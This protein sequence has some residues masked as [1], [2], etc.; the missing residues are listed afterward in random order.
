MYKKSRKNIE[1][2]FKK[3]ALDS[4]DIKNAKSKS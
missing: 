2:L 3:N 1:S 4:E